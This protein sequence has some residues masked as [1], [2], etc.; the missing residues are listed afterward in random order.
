[1]EKFCHTRIL[2]RAAKLTYH[3]PQGN[4]Y[5]G[6]ASNFVTSGQ[7]VD[8]AFNDASDAGTWTVIVTNPS[9]QTSTAFSFTVSA[10]VVAPSVSSVSPNPVPGS[11]SGQSLTITGSNFVSGATLT[12]HDPQGNSYPGHA[13]NFVTSGQLV[14]PAFN[15]ASDAGTWTV[16]VANPSGHTSAAFNFTVR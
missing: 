3:D 16:I 8:P 2:I 6:H 1:V 5:P 10:A 15:D 12:Y 14:D 7:L 4:S 13:S 11:N 9:G